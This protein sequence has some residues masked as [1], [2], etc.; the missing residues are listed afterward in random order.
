MLAP[1]ACV[2]GAF[3]IAC[4]RGALF[5]KTFSQTPGGADRAEKKIDDFEFS[6]SVGCEEPASFEQC[7]K[8]WLG[9]VEEQACQ[10]NDV[11]PQDFP[12]KLGRSEGPAVCKT[13]LLRE[14]A[15]W[16]KCSSNIVARAVGSL[17]VLCGKL[18][19]SPAEGQRSEDYLVGMAKLT[20]TT[21]EL[22]QDQTSAEVLLEDL[23]QDESEE[24]SLEEQMK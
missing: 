9:A 15:K 14:E 8:E 5:A 17:A 4:G 22:N 10:L 19:V 11:D 2:D 1:R 18:L 13:T 23:S 20:A 7:L 21:V 12:R 6:W 16:R 24:D 3:E